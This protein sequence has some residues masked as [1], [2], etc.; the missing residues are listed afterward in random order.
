MN[1]R[2]INAAGVQLVLE[3]REI[4][5]TEIDS[6]SIKTNS[7]RVMTVSSTL[8][9]KICSICNQPFTAGRRN[10]NICSYECKKIHNREHARFYARMRRN[11][12]DKVYQPCVVC[13]YSETTDQH[14]ENGRK[15]TL[16]PNHH[17]LITRNIKTLEELLKH[18][19]A[20]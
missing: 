17:C 10:K 2:H 6:D 12:I 1:G 16:C 14:S 3:E 18:K 13:G 8:Y 7:K 5:E 9:E 19:T 20:P 15:Y 11:T 4:K